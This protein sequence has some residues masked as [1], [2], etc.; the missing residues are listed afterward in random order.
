MPLPRVSRPR[1]QTG[2]CRFSPAGAIEASHEQDRTVR[3]RH[4]DV[5]LFP[6]LV[7]GCVGQ[8]ARRRL[9]GLSDPV[10]PQHHHSRAL[11]RH[12]PRQAGAQR[13][14]ISGDQAAL[15]AQPAAARGLAFL[16]Q[17]GARSW[18]RG[19][20]DALLCS[21]DHRDAACRADPEGRRAA[22]PLVRRFHRLR[23]RAHRL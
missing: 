14:L 15:R 11:P 2:R 18:P 19:D 3:H 22:D 17:R 1:Y 5:F 9:F 21:A 8:M 4:D 12:R 10:Y 20:D 16:F 7:A 23:R 6:V 13:H